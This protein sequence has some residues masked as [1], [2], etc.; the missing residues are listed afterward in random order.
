MVGWSVNFAQTIGWLE[1]HPILENYLLRLRGITSFNKAF[2]L[3]DGA[4]F[5]VE[6]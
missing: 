2:S 3:L 5:Y 1:G 4:P 6:H